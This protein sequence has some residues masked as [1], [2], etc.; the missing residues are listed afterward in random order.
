MQ[1]GCLYVT[2]APTETDIAV[3]SSTRTASRCAV[4][5][6]ALTL[7][8]CAAHRG[9][10]SSFAPKCASSRVMRSTDNAGQHLL[11]CRSRRA[12]AQGLAWRARD[13]EARRRSGA[14]IASASALTFE[15]MTTTGSGIT[16]SEYNRNSSQQ[17]HFL[18]V[19]CAR[20]DAAADCPDLGHTKAARIEARLLPPPFQRRVEA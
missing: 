5:R 17:V 4:C 16:H 9:L 10:R 7:T 15:Q 3:A 19:R 6:R 13:H 2:L 1:F 18:Q 12:R 8:R 14:W 11:L 20:M